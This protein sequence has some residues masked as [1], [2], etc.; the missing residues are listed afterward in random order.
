MSELI[1]LLIMVKTREFG[2]TLERLVFFIKYLVSQPE[3]ERM[4]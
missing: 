1:R 3:R 4:L 2:E